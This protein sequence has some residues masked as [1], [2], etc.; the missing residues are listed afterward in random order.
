MDGNS[1]NNFVDPLGRG[2]FLPV[3]L[4]G[5][6]LQLALTRKLLGPRK[7]RPPCSGNNPTPFFERTYLEIHIVLNADQMSAEIE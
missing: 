3:E 6:G 5:A 1:R 2:H 4:S 7:I